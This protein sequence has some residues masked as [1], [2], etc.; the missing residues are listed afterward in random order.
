MV[1][2][3][4][5]NKRKIGISLNMGLLLMGCL[6]L[7]IGAYPAL[8]SGSAN[9]T[10][11]SIG[12]VCIAFWFLSFPALS[13]ETKDKTI[14]ALGIH[15]VTA[16]SVLIIFSLEVHYILINLKKGSPWGDIGFC[17]GGIIVCSYLCYIF[18]SFIKTFYFLIQKVRRLLFPN[19][20]DQ[21]VS[22]ILHLLEMASSLIVSLTA[23]VGSLTAACVAVQTFLEHIY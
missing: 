5:T 3:I 20:T 18:I 2:M 17:I 7:T 1:N 10:R 14:V 4:N 15:A 21:N 23:F 9:E 8:Y 16:L 6:M 19:S 22:G 12:A 11:L 13:R